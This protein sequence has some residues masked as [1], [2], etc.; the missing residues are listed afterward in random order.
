MKQMDVVG[1]TR[2]Q[3]TLLMKRY[4]DY[5]WFSGYPNKLYFQLYNSYM[6]Q[7]KSDF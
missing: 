6:H 4:P 2:F 7:D 3:I 5:L 1:C